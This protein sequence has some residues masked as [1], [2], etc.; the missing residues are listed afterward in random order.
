[1]EQQRQAEWQAERQ[2]EPIGEEPAEPLVV[3]PERLVAGRTGNG[4]WCIS[5]IL[6]WTTWMTFSIT[7]C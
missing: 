4:A 2:A 7:R 5:P 6:Q 3:Q 1:M